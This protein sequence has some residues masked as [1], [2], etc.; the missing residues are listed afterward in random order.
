MH[1]DIGTFRSV[2]TL[3]IVECVNSSIRATLYSSR[4]GRDSI[5]LFNRAFGNVFKKV[6]WDRRISIH[7][8][9][10]LLCLKSINVMINVQILPTL[11]LDVCLLFLRIG[12]VTLPHKFIVVSWFARHSNFRFVIILGRRVHLILAC[13][14]HFLVH[15]VHVLVLT[16][17]LLP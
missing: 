14:F 13:R 6:T 10:F 16:L 15:W 7:I 1:G 5:L 12:I 4:S 17:F 11:I 2:A 3:S 8:E 9:G